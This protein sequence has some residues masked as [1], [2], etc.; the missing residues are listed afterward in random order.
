M[1]REIIF[2]YSC[3]DLQLSE[4]EFRAHLE[5]VHG[6]DLDVEAREIVFQ[7]STVT[8]TYR[9]TCGPVTFSMTASETREGEIGEQ[10]K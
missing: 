6:V 4:D 7:K 2:T 3:C 8:I 10:G 9:T 1:S 5:T